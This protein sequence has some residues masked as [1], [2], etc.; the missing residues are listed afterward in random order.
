MTIKAIKKISNNKYKIV[1]DNDKITL[2]DEVI[3]NNNLLFKKEIDD[4]FLIKLKKDNDYYD[5]YN[6]VVKMINT[7]L[8]SE[9][10]INKY[11]DKLEITID[12]KNDIINKLKGNGLINDNNYA[13]AYIY[14]RMYLSNDGPV[15]IKKELLCH[16]INENI[17]DKL[18][19]D[20]DE[21]YLY[22]K[23]NK[24]VL[25]KVKANHKYSDYILKTKIQ[26]DMINLGYDRDFVNDIL[27]GINIDN[28]S[29]IRNDYD[30]LISKYSKKY[31]GNELVYK[32]KE[33]LYQKGY[34]NEDIN[35]IIN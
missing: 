16:N 6:K 26:S 25:K 7:K 35:K 24:L 15:K 3:I 9:N 2:Y 27:N 13:K 8:R 30:K 11:L 29:L 21:D 31:S 18:L 17:V 19:N 10:E 32:V 33:K 23:L 14:D 4:E 34:S 5:V 12:Y 1:L 22:N 28:S 20:I